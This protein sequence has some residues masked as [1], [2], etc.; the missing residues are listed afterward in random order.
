LQAD[1]VFGADNLPAARYSFA[2]SWITAYAL[3]GFGSTCHKLYFVQDFEPFFYSNGSE[4]D[5]AEE[6]YKFG[7]TGIC[8]GGWLEHKLNAEYGMKTHSV[9]FS[10]DRDLYVQ[11]YRREPEKLRVFCYC[12]P[13][14]IRRGLE[15]SMLALSLVGNER[16]DVEFIFAGWDMGNYYFPYPHLNGGCLSL[17]ELP[18]LY[19]QC[20][21]ALVFSFTNLSLLPLELMACGCVVVS[22]RAPNTEWLL[23]DENS[24]LPKSASPRSIANAII[25]ILDDAPRRKALAQRAKIFAQSTNWLDEGE[26]FGRQEYP[27]KKCCENLRRSIRK[28]TGVVTEASAKQT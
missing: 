7:F 9:S 19:S 20:D 16:P 14:T 12:R 13:P 23:N 25:D 5:F 11:T 26:K 3:R 6:T 4:Y 24:I 2:T 1:V 22:N 15:S 27:K 18:D 28:S 21:V 8:A 10:Y 17:K